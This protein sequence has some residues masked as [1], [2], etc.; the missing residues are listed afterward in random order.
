MSLYLELIGI[1]C[2]ATFPSV[3]LLILLSHPQRFLFLQM[4]SRAVLLQKLLQRETT[5]NEFSRWQKRSRRRRR[6]IGRGEKRLLGENGKKK[7]WRKNVAG[8]ENIDQRKQ[9]QKRKGKDVRLVVL[10]SLLHGHIVEPQMFVLLKFMIRV[11][12]TYTRYRTVT[13]IAKINGNFL[14]SK[15]IFLFYLSYPIYK[16]LKNQIGN[17]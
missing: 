7:E 8:D 2:E 13:R 15:I 16:Q 5:S 12:I 10:S 14:I 6:E 1:P 4:C 9:G 11:Y 17:F 3:S